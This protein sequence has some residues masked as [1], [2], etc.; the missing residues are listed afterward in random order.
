[1]TNLEK[2]QAYKNEATPYAM[3]QKIHGCFDLLFPHNKDEYAWIDVGAGSGLALV[4]AYN[5]GYKETVGLENNPDTT[6]ISHEVA[7]DIQYI[8]ALDYPYEHH[9]KVILYLF[10]PF[11]DKVM[12][13]FVERIKGLEGFLIYLNPVHR[14]QLMF[15][16]LKMSTLLDLGKFPCAIYR[17]GE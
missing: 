14:Q 8:S 3:S 12:E 15:S 1:M 10:N 4:E 17:L 13:K 11:S 2:E 6:F 7:A 16:H 9:K 5:A